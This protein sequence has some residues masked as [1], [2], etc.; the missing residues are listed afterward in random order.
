VFSDLSGPYIAGIY[1]EDFIG[2]VV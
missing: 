1:K 2:T